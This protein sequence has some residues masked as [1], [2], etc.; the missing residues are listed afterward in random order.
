MD[1]QDIRMIRKR[2]K[3]DFCNNK[4]SLLVYNNHNNIRCKI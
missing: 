3:C 2:F 1:N 4:M